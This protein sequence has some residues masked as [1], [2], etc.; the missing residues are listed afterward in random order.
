MFSHSFAPPDFV[1]SSSIPIPKGA[2][3]TP[4]DSENYRSIAINSLLS[5]ALEHIIIDHQGRGILLSH[6][7]IN[8]ALSN[9]HLRYY[10]QQFNIII[11]REL[12]LYIVLLDASKTFDKVSFYTLVNVYYMYTNQSCY[13]TWSNNRSE[14]FNISN[15]IKQGGVI[16]PLLFSNLFLELRTIGLVCHVAYVC[17]FG[18]T[19]NIALIAPAIYSLEK[20]IIICENYSLTHCMTFNP[21]KSKSK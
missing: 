10:V 7:I 16:S 1:I 4:T 2:R 11:Q 5:K 15:G 6:Q 20:I 17:A 13:V 21:S 12:N 14:T 3:I 9:N 18:Y 8:L 19:Y